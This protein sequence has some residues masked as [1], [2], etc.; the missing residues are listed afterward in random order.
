MFFFLFCFLFLFF[1]FSFFD[2]NCGSISLLF[3]KNHVRV[4]PAYTGRFEYTRKAFL[5]LHTAVI[6]SSAYQEKPT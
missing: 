2:R 1:D 5:S 4:L 3:Q 6:A